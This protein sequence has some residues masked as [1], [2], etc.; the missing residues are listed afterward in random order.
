MPSTVLCHDFLCNN[1]NEYC[2]NVYKN[3]SHKTGSFRRR[4]FSPF[5]DIV[6]NPAESFKQS[7]IKEKY[8]WVKKKLIAFL[9]IRQTN[10]FIRSHFIYKLNSLTQNF[11]TRIAVTFSKFSNFPQHFYKMN[12]LFWANGCYVC[13]TEFSI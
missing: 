4:R 1:K 10:F 5:L 6:D 3:D 11:I 12:N 13:R 9:F 7:A 8:V 2:E